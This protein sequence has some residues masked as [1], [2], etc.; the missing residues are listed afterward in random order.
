M[1]LEPAVSTSTSRMSYFRAMLRITRGTMNRSSSPTTPS[2]GH[3]TFFSS[4]ATVL[5]E[6]WSAARPLSGTRRDKA[7]TASSGGS[8]F[9]DSSRWSSGAPLTGF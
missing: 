5:S 9:S 8:L 6:S 3:R 7:A 1:P 4:T 2:I